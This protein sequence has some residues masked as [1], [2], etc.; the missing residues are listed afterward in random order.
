MTLRPW[1]N[2]TRTNDNVTYDKAY[3]WAGDEA[4]CV[5]GPMAQAGMGEAVGPS[6]SRKRAK[7]GIRDDIRPGTG[8][9][10]ASTAVRLSGPKRPS[11]T[12]LGQRPRTRA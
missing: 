12:S 4:C 10:A 9:R 2:P 8:R 6:L 11:H 5:P 7:R 3:G 1:R